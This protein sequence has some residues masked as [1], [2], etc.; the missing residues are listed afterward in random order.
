MAH[1]QQ[2][3]YDPRLAS[4]ATKHAAQWQTT[5]TGE[6]EGN[7]D[8]NDDDNAAS[9]SGSDGPIFDRITTPRSRGTSAA[10][11]IYTILKMRHKLMY[12]KFGVLD[13]CRYHM[14]KYPSSINKRVDYFFEIYNERPLIA[15]P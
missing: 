3:F 6:D 4:K 13:W 15:C 11:Y 8:K 12:A 2:C 10:H 9:G 5:T 14:K 1:W 7:E